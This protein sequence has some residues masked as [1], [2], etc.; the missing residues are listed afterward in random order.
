MPREPR[1]YHLSETPAPYAHAVDRVFLSAAVAIGSGIL[2]LILQWAR[3]VQTW[4]WVVLACGLIGGV[5]GVVQGILFIKKNFPQWEQFHSKRLPP[6]D[7]PALAEQVMQFAGRAGLEKVDRIVL[8]GLTAVFGI[9]LLSLFL[10][11]VASGPP[12]YICLFAL[13]VCGWAYTRQRRVT[14]TD[15]KFRMELG[16]GGFSVSAR[17]LATPD[18]VR[19]A[20]RPSSDRFIAWNEIDRWE[21]ESGGSDDPAVYCV[22]LRSKERLQIHRSHFLGKEIPLLNKVRACGV[23]VILKDTVLK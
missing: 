20:S 13:L 14:A 6:R 16:K 4:L 23:T 22:Y 3:N 18:D 19:L 1:E 12:L 9:L 17:I 21:V 15:D 8:I 7:D 11:G 2:S 5:F 10:Y